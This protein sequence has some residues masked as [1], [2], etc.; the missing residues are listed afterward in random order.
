MEQVD[1]AKLAYDSFA[2]IYDDFNHRND[3]EMWFGALLPR[4]EGLGLQKGRLLDVACGTG[5][6]F[7]P[8]LRRGWDITACDISAAMVAKAVEKHPGDAIAFDVVDMRELPVYGSFQLVWA[9]N[10]AVS[11]LLGDGDLVPAFRAMGANLAPEGLLVFDCNTLRLFGDLFGAGPEETGG[12]GRWTWRGLG[13][14]GPFWEA[15]LSVPGLPVQRHRE[16][17]RPVAEVQAALLDADLVPLAAM[18][19]SED[20]G[21]LVIADDWDEDRD[22]KILHVARRR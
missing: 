7:G 4:L 10:D 15:E 11:Y 20:D 2:E 9:L 5:R 1:P 3:Y 21:T 19:Q 17:H 18:G 16:R 13:D 14:D 22:H 8:M 12:G 6:A